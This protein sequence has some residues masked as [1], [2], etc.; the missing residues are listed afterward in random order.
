M[1]KTPVRTTDNPDEQRLEALLEDG[2]VAGFAQYRPGEGS[3]EFT[4]TEVGDEYD[5]QGIGSQLAAGVMEYARDRGV[6]VE[7][8]CSFL[9]SYMKRHEETHDLLAPGISLGP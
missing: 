2:T 3:F 1:A 8:S 5:G 9:R 7:P 6:K 4:H